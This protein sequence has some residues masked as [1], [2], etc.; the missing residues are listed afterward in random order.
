MEWLFDR[1]LKSGFTAVLRSVR[2]GRI[3]WAALGCV[4]GVVALLAVPPWVRVFVSPLAMQRAAVAF[5]V[6]LEFVYGLVLGAALLGGLVLGCILWRARARGKTRTKA[7]R[8]LL[9]CGSTLFA[10]F[11]AEA[12]AG[13]WEAW[14]HRMP[15]FPGK[16]GALELPT[17]FADREGDAV[18]N[19]VVVGESSAAGYPY[20]DWLSVGK[21]LA[22]QLERAIPGRRFHLDLLA[23][24]GDTLEGQ[25][26]KL[27]RL[28]TRPDLL[29]VYCGHNEF[30]VH[31]PW[32]REVDYYKDDQSAPPARFLGNLA[33]RISPLCRMIRETAD[34]YQVHIVPPPHLVW[35]LVGVPSYTPAEYAERPIDFRRRLEAIVAFAER[36]GALPVLVIPPG[37]DAGFEPN[38]SF[39]SAGTPRAERAVFARAFL[40]AR[41]MESGDPT[42]AIE[43]YR[44]LLARQPCFAEAHFRLARL[45]E[46]ASAW[47]EAYHQYVA[48][49]DLDGHPLRCLT[50]FQE[51]YREVAVRHNCILIDSQALFHTIG[52]HGMLD[53]HLFHDAMH[54][55]L[56]GHIVLAGA[57]LKA[58]QGRQAFGWPQGSPAAAI[59]PAECAAHFGL[60][61][62]SWEYV[63]EHG[64]LFYYRTAPLRYDPT[65]R[66][67]KQRA[68]KEAARHITE[69]QPPEQVG[70]PNIGVPV[71]RQ[72]RDGKYP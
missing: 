53:D 39:L 49:R 38:R 35:P 51:A 62:K 65:E 59:D 54:P 66:R 61:R 26:K 19:L 70:L 6:G 12:A 21:I 47:E 44:E 7:A 29:I 68:F 14:T 25:H 67:A 52:P 46:H 55:S 24:P 60:D 5:L 71:M 42:R 57:I 72:G 28:T 33:G 9:V 13:A 40:A 41:Q 18:V 34:R 69:G 11:L 36:A 30:G 45:L 1:A 43:R 50:S 48:A 22:W 8:G 15:A 20:Q 23:E 64:A 63:C 32:S 16:P 27:A 10:L 31:T 2:A 4:A 3:W 17:R 56:R 58:L 37:N